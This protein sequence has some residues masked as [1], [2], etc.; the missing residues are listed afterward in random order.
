[1][2]PTS[3]VATVPSAPLL[4][5]YFLKLFVYVDKPPFTTFISLKLSYYSQFIDCGVRR[6]SYGLGFGQGEHGFYFV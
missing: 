2:K 5:K 4:C 1:M 3:E 6:G